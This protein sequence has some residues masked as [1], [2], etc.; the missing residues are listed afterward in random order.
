MASHRLR[1]TPFLAFIIVLANVSVTS[2]QSAPDVLFGVQYTMNGGSAVTVSPVTSSWSD[3][4]QIPGGT[5]TGFPAGSNVD[6]NVSG[7]VSGGSVTATGSVDVTGPIGTNDRDGFAEQNLYIYVRAQGAT[8]TGTY[9]A[10]LSGNVNISGV[11][12]YSADGSFTNNF[13]A[14][15]S[16][17]VSATSSNSGSYSD[18]NVKFDAG[19]CTGGGVTFGAYPGVSYK[20]MNFGA[21]RYSNVYGGASGLSSSNISITATGT[22]SVSVVLGAATPVAQISGP[23]VSS[24]SKPI[25]DT[26]DSVKFNNLSYDPDNNNGTT[27]LEGICSR[28]WEVDK[29][30]GTTLT[31]TTSAASYTFTADIPGKYILRLTVVDNEGATSQ[32]E[33]PFA[34]SPRPPGPGYC[35]TNTPTF[36]LDDNDVCTSVSPGTGNPHLAHR[37]G[38][39]TRGNPLSTT[40]HVDSQTNFPTRTTAMGNAN[41]VY[42][43]RVGSMTPS[44]GS[45]ARWFLIDGDGSE[46]D[47]GAASGSPAAP[48]YAHSTLAVTGSGFT[49]TAAGP[50]GSAELAGNFSYEFDSAGKLLTITDPSGNDQSLTYDS[51]GDLT[52]VTDVNSNRS[53]QFE[54]DTPGAIARIVEGGGHRVT[55]L[56]YGSGKLTEILEKD[57]LGATVR[58]V[59][60]TYNSDGLLATVRKNND[61]GSVISVSYTDQGNGTFLANMTYP[62]GATNY[63]Y[64][65]APPTGA[66]YRVKRTNTQGGLIT[67]D[68]TRRGKLLKVTYP[69][70][71]GTSSTPSET[72]TYDSAENVTSAVIKNITRNYTYDSLGNLLTISI[73][74]GG[75]AGFNRTYTY[76]GVDLLTAADTIGTFATLA[77]T[78][79]SNPH[80]PTT[81]T[82]AGGKVWSRA[83]NSYG[84]LTT[85]TPPSSSPTSATAIAYED[86]PLDADFGYLRSVTNGAGDVQTFDSYSPVGEVLSQTTSPASGVTNTTT[87]AYDGI[88]RLISLA[89]PDSKTLSWSYSGTKLAST[90]DEAGALREFTWDP[91]VDE[92]ISIEEPL[93]KTLSWDYDGDHNLT[94]FS[95]PRSNDT[96]Y[97]YGNSGEL[98]LVTYPDNSTVQYKYDSV[99]K[100]VQMINPRGRELNFSYDSSGRFDGYTFTNPSQ[101]AQSVWYRADNLVTSDSQ[102]TGTSTYTY[103][104]GR[105]LDTASFNYSNSGLSPTQKLIYTYNNDGSR[106]TMTWKSNTTTIVT[107]TYSYDAAGRLSG[108]SNSFG[109][110]STFAYDDEGKITTHTNGNGTTIEYAYNNARGWPTAITHKASGTAFETYAI[111]YDGGLDTVGNLTEVTELSG[112][113]MI[114]EYDDLYRLTL[115]T[116]TGTNAYSKSYDYDPSNNITGVDGSTF[117]TY[118]SANRISSLASGTIGYDTSG[119]VTSLSAF[120]LPNGTFTFETR[121]LMGTQSDGTT[122]TTYNYHFD[123][124]RLLARPGS[125]TT[126]YRWYIFDG[127]RLVGEIGTGG[128][129]VAYTWGVDGITSE[130]IIPSNKSLYY[131]FG[132]QG[133]TRY[134]T[135]SGGTVQDSYRYTAFGVLLTTSGADYNPHRY[136]GKHGYFTDGA[137]GLVLAS[138][139]WYSP[140]LMRWMSRDPIEYEGGPNLYAYVSGNPVKL[141]DPS[142][143]DE[144]ISSKVEICWAPAVDPILNLVKINHYWLKTTVRRRYSKRRAIG[145]RYREVGLWAR[146]P[147]KGSWLNSEWGNSSKPG[148]ACVEVPDID[149]ECV[150][151]HL[152]PGDYYG[153]FGA[154]NNCQ[155]FVEGTLNECDLQPQPWWKKYYIPRHIV[156]Y[157]NKPPGQRLLE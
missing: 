104:S 88:G 117:A 89:H 13:W 41:F 39:L 7:S 124:R 70:P 102:F 10:V 151:G 50:P 68:F 81:I 12:A 23:I 150:E 154:G 109:E 107:W 20:Q 9:T 115:E 32:T 37:G 55:H 31:N 105:Q 78:D 139:R 47:Y 65:F 111:E 97:T 149:G 63:N 66:A 136:G 98:K 85:V 28:T 113:K 51:N 2:A 116:R 25:P 38:S 64:A 74:G 122:T 3:Q 40:I 77:Y 91:A 144:V 110:S 106:A 69:A 52:D 92:L 108:V 36:C 146:A 93:S 33:F 100:L 84:Q 121:E 21:T 123:G 29:P 34:V 26:G 101:T 27:A 19:S 24:V 79:S 44:G 80:S 130:R 134:L 17:N 6:Q 1:V 125:T 72:F 16:L 82:D 126:N 135:G 8:P 67:Y 35:P 22:T 148:A 5:G 157:W 49:L 4:I 145:T 120:G 141:V 114:Y 119:N 58:D 45:T 43:M 103:T 59:D 57:S 127:N 138:R 11:T 62:G 133:E 155:A 131:H 99:G 61:A 14:P 76:S 143:L 54:Y 90:L 53:L 15:D 60:L 94:E 75:S 42:G 140:H 152:N 30:D 73:T 83:Y 95:D 142:G 129:K 46:H 112:D 71:N 153:R 137:L 118:D 86:D 132:P 156:D 48:T 128:A 18:T 147:Y 96:A 87:Y 56:S